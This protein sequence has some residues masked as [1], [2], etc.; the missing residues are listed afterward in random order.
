MPKIMRKGESQLR[1]YICTHIYNLTRTQTL[2]FF[3]KTAEEYLLAFP[4]LKKEKR[5]KEKNT[6]DDHLLKANAPI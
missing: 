5:R 6:W 4:C 1:F 2:I 3:S